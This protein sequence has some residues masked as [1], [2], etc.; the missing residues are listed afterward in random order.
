MVGIVTDFD[1][2]RLAL[3][4]FEEGLDNGCNSHDGNPYEVDGLNV[5]SE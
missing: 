4:A 1:G 2:V 5:G 3:D